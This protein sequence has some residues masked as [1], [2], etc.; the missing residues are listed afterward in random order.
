M[1]GVLQRFCLVLTVSLGAGCA[2]R[3]APTAGSGVGLRFD[4][5]NN[6][7]SPSPIIIRRDGVAVRV[8]TT[9]ATLNLMAI[10][11][12]VDDLGEAVGVVE[13]EVTDG[14]R[15]RL[16]LVETAGS[17]GLAQGCDR[18]LVGNIPGDEDHT[19]RQIRSMA[20]NPG[21]HLP[22]IDA[23]GGAHVGKH[24]QIRAVFQ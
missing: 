9:D 20:H 8:I 1:N 13:I 22:A 16:D 17:A 7:S 15:P 10:H 3:A 4:F 14:M 12:P 19:R 5:A 2:E 18:F 21:M 6:P 11:G 24:T 23:A